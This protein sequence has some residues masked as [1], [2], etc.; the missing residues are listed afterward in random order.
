MSTKKELLEQELKEVENLYVEKIN[1]LKRQIKECD[2]VKAT[3]VR[4]AFNP[5]SENTQE[6]INLD[7]NI[8]VGNIV[9]C[10]VSFPENIKDYK[11][12]LVKSIEEINI[13]HD[14]VN[15]YRKCFK[16]V[17]R[18]RIGKLIQKDDNGYCCGTIGDKTNFT[19]EDGS[20]MNVGDLVELININ[21]NIE[22]KE[23]CICK[24]KDNSE[25]VMGIAGEKIKHGISENKT[26]KIKLIKKYYE[27]ENN[28]IAY[29]YVKYIFD[30]E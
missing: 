4:V 19:Y 23:T 30:N 6:F 17:N 14:K 10:K 21:N 18:N 13:S 24:V 5:K 8:K 27:V 2:M 15:R 11:L 7:N 9:E 3:I 25:F 28:Y 1:D 22:K 26:W 16:F 12:A 20:K 29:D